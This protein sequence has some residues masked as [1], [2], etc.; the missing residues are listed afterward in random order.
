MDKTIRLSCLFLNEVFNSSGAYYWKLK[1]NTSTTLKP[2]NN[3]NEN[4]DISTV[5]KTSNSGSTYSDIIKIDPAYEGVLTFE[6]I[7]ISS[8]DCGQLYQINILPDLTLAIPSPLIKVCSTNSTSAN[9]ISTTQLSPLPLINI[10]NAGQNISW[11]LTNTPSAN[12]TDVVITNSSGTGSSNQQLT[13]F[14]YASNL[15]TTKRNDTITVNL[16]PSNTV[17][18]VVCGTGGSAVNSIDPSSCTITPQTINITVY[19]YIAAGDNTSATICYNNTANYNLHINSLFFNNNGTDSSAKLGSNVITTSTSGLG[20][21]LKV[22]YELATSTSNL[23]TALA[24]IIWGSFSLIGEYTSSCNPNSPG[25]NNP[26][27]F[28]LPS[29]T[30][31]QINF[32]KIK[33][34]VEF[35]D[36]NNVECFKIAEAILTINTPQN[37]TVTNTVTICN[38]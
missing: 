32:I 36:S 33:R 20:T 1:S 13:S 29:L 18:S 7:T 16:N 14:K 26:C 2:K 17:G 35:L 38:T 5:I 31:P 8:N 23:S 15:S 27:A 6:K 25:P 9:L 21:T 22:R 28:T 19:P 37:Q 24:N 30:S 3:S 34:T 11:S 12:I 4:I 10:G